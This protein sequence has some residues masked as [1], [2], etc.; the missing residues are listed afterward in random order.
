MISRNEENLDLT[1]SQE[2]KYDF[3]ITA[4]KGELTFDQIR[5][6]IQSNSK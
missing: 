5:Q 1:A 6:W 3:V 4:A 2:I